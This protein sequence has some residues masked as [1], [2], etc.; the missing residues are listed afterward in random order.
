MW[1]ATAGVIDDTIRSWV[2]DLVN[3]LYGFLHNIFGLVGAGWDKFVTELHFAWQG[4]A[5]FMREVT[6]S[7][8]FIVHYLFPATLKRIDALVG[9]VKHY[10]IDVYDFAVHVYDTLRNLIAAGL[11][12][13]K[14][15]VLQDVYKPLFDF[16][17]QAWHWITHE[18]A[19]VFYYISHPAAL[20]E[21]IWDELVAKLEAEA[22]N[23]GSKLGKFF[24]SL[25]VHNLQR[26]VLLLE[27]ILS[28]LL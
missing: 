10:A 5:G 9:A 20:V 22:W 18:G 7:L 13:L 23:I 14:T 19:V 1:D 6:Y 28:A 12:D 26:F 4:L 17:T 2:H 27:D 16:I 15:F 21:L 25:I 11:R 3:G 8:S 24:V